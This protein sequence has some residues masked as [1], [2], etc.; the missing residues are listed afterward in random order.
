MKMGQYSAK[1]S[2]SRR[3]TKVR[4]IFRTIRRTHM[5]RFKL[6]A[7]T[8][9]GCK[10]FNVVVNVKADDEILVTVDKEQNVRDL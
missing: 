6:A 10:E 7:C 1:V 3:S 2:K 8:G 9:T 5:P 4:V